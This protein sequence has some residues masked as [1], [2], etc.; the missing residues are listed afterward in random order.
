M[1][2][3]TGEAIRNRLMYAPFI[4][5]Y[6][7]TLTD[8]ERCKYL[9]VSEVSAVVNKAITSSN[10]TCSGK[11]VPV[12]TTNM[13]TKL[14]SPVFVKN[15]GVYMGLVNPERRAMLEKHLSLVE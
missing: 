11:E 3:K 13:L 7:S 10:Q 9:M 2:V 8:D 6:M 5:Q 1:K 12:L 4:R 14:L 15:A